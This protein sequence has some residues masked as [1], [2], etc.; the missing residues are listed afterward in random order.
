M[1][2]RFG[3][4]IKSIEEKPFY[5]YLLLAVIVLL[6]VVLRFYKLGDWSFWIDEIYTINHATRHFGSLE[7]IFNHIPPVGR[8]IPLSVILT[9]QAMNTWG[10]NEW[11]ARFISATIG[12]LS[13]PILYVPLRKAFGNW[14]ALIALL[15][16]AV[17]TWHIFWSQNARFYTS[18]LLFY[19]LTLFAFYFAIEHDRPLFLIGFYALFYLALSERMIAVL[20][21]PVIIVYLLSVWLL[22]FA[23]PAGLRPRNL[24]ILAA[25]LIAFLA[26][27]IY[28]FVTT[29]DFIFATDLDLLAPPI[30]T[31]IRLLSLS[32][33]SI[34]IPVVCLAAFSGIYLYLEKKRSGLFFLISAMLPLLLIAMANPFVFTVERYA[35]MTLLFWVALAANGIT[36]IFALARRHQTVLAIGVLFLLLADAA[37]SNLMYFQINHGDRLAWRE[38]AEYVNTKMQPGD[39][40]VSTRAPLA[41]YYLGQDTLEFQDLLAADLEEIDAPL[42]FIVDFPGIWHGK[43]ESRAWMEE[44]AQL[45][46]FSYL[47]VREYNYLLIY[48]F[49]PA[50]ADVP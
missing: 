9:A 26:Y 34:G 28:L 40:I 27:E 36:A 43:D 14:V 7:L 30:D 13:L 31:P 41:S 22:P 18:L 37:G 38:A 32:V 33:F 17:S 4:I 48:F 45:M 50:Q 8:W 46:Q 39:V 2:D 11:S 3:S 35:F 44:H 24:L 21:W 5:Q 15:I 23:K 42:W 47:R 19:S 20:I 6:S 16:L 25:P 49:D 12:V 29:G 10:V 1:D